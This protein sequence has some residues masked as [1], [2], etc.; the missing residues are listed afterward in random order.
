[1]E[2]KKMGDTWYVRM[3]KGDELISS[4]LSICRKEE[5]ASAVYTGIGACESADLQT[6]LPEEGIF[7]TEHLEGML[8][9]INVTGNII[10]E[11]PGVLHHHTHAIFSYKEDG[12]HK[13]TAGHVK[14]MTVLYTAEIELR[15]VKDGVIYRK[16][17]EETGTGFWDLRKA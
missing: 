13:V 3:D 9:L 8:E 5:I 4:L 2:Y 11:E 1:M 6:F 10:T 15:P 12:T 17:D 16:Y 7:E 14:Q